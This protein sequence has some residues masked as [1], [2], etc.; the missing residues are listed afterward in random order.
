M[1]ILAYTND[2]DHEYLQECAN[3]EA[4]DKAMSY[5]REGL[6]VDEAVSRACSEVD[7]GYADYY[8]EDDPMYWISPD[9]DDVQKLVEDRISEDKWRKSE[10]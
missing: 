2:E 4:F 10:N 9:S 1:K 7:N 8:T 6:S 5:Y 3:D